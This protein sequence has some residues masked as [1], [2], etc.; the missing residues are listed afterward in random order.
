MSISILQVEAKHESRV[1]VVFTNTLAAGAFGVP[2]PAYYTITCT[3]ARG[4]DPGVQAALIVSGSTTVVELVLEYPLVKSAFYLLEAVG[5]PATDLSVT[6]AGSEVPFR[7]GLFQAAVDK[8]PLKLDRERLLYGVDLLW[9]G[10]DYQES[11]TGDL[12]TVG[13]TANV[14]KAL[15]RGVE[16]NGLPWDDTWGVKAR[17]YVDSPST[18]TGPSGRRCP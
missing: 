12:S 2:A 8:E 18:A 11:A 7:F 13:G 10:T 4:P 14:T 3:D 16:A 15:N 5:V 1:R 17:E 6:P 9:N